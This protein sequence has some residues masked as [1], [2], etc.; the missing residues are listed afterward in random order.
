LYDRASEA[1]KDMIE[2][3]IQ[4][5]DDYLTLFPDGLRPTG[6]HR[7]QAREVRDHLSALV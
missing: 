1:S 5:L 2:M 4:D 7:S 3:G 6:G